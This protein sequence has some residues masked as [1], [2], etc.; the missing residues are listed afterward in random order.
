MPQLVI[1]ITIAEQREYDINKYPVKMRSNELPR[2]CMI[3]PERERD[4]ETIRRHTDLRFI[5]VVED[6][7]FES[8]G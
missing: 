1:L 4:S 3:D 2:G 5:Q 7:L 8:G 6:K